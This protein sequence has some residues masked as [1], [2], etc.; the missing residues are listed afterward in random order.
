M[1]ADSVTRLET[2]EPRGRKSVRLLSKKGY[3]HGTVMIADVEH[4]PVGC[5]TWPA[6][7]MVGDGWPCQLS[8]NL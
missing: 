1:R 4:M 3:S 5:G 6:L 8:F 2:W 7:W